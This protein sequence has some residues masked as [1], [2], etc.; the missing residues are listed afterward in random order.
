MGLVENISNLIKIVGSKGLNGSLKQLSDVIK[1]G[2]NRDEAITLMGWSESYY[3]NTSNELRERLFRKVYDLP[4]KDLNRSRKAFI[5]SHKDYILFKILSVFRANELS[6]FL[7]QRGLR[8]STKFE[9]SLLKHEFATELMRD[10]AKKGDSKEFEYYKNISQSSLKDHQ[11]EFLA[12]CEFNKISVIH[13][14]NLIVEKDIVSQINESLQSLHEAKEQTNTYRFSL[15]Y[16]YILAL[17]K[18]FE[19]DFDSL[20]TICQ[21]AI[22]LFESKPFETPSASKSLFYLKQIFVY[23]NKNEY[24]KS[25]ELCNKVMEVEFKSS[26]NYAIALQYKVF[27]SFRA[28]KFDE[29]IGM[30]QQDKNWNDYVN[31]VWKV[32]IAYI[33]LL[34]HYNQIQKPDNLPQF[35]LRKFLNETP[36]LNK[37]K[38]GFN[39]SV[40]ILQI[41]FLVNMKRK[42][43]DEFADKAESIS[44]YIRK[45]LHGRDD[46]KRTRIFMKILLE[47]PKCSYRKA[48]FAVKT[49]HLRKDLEKTKSDIDSQVKELEIIPYEDLVSMVDGVL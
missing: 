26:R 13:S 20:L 15:L 7:C 49:K 42:G 5:Q 8:R 22:N 41:M 11:N 19:K 16:Y 23:T 24:E 45:Y 28:N 33:Y 10:A 14:T 44:Q 39:I 25:I 38:L 18:E 48:P 21:D 36:L 47:L 12:N 46:L 34:I 43:R 1:D 37:D 2:K 4:T 3:Q 30:L 27:V 6:S 17:Q 32:I 35:K 9:L 31:Q 29:I 40:Q